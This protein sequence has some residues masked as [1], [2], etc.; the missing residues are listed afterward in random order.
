MER[1]VVIDRKPFSAKDGRE[2]DEPPDK[3]FVRGKDAVKRN[4]PS[5]GL[6]ERD[7]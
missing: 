5:R 4:R 2:S 3:G 6:K 1:T 7:W